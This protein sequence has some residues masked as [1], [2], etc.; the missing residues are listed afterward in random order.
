MDGAVLPFFWPQPTSL[1]DPHQPFAD[2]STSCHCHI[3]KNFAA[4][5]S[6]FPACAVGNHAKNNFSDNSFFN[7]NCRSYPITIVSFVLP[8]N[9]KFALLF[10]KRFPV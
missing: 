8:T 7:F 6:Y 1:L 9:L 10:E 3:H 2:F 5:P 4:K